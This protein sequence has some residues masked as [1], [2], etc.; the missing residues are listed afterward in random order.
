MG[1]IQKI[2][3]SIYN[4]KK[5]QGQLGQPTRRPRWDDIRRCQ[6]RL[7]KITPRTKRSQAHEG[8]N[9]VGAIENNEGHEGSAG[10]GK[11][12]AARYG[13]DDEEAKSG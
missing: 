1:V 11:A 9:G 12:L 4:G 2:N 6:T 8:R 7:S 13:A 3:M 5:L 10:R